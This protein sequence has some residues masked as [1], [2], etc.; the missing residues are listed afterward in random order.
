MANT[1]DFSTLI[2]SGNAS[3]AFLT[4]DFLTFNDSI[5]ASDLIIATSGANITIKL[6]TGFTLTLTSFTQKQVASTNFIFADGSKLIIG[7]GF[8]TASSDDLANTLVGTE[9]NDYLDGGLGIDTVSYAGANSAVTVDLSI[10]SA[11]DTIGA[12]TDKLLNIENI[13]GS[14]YSDTLAGDGNANS[15]DGGAGIDIMDGKNGSD[16]YFVTAGD[17]VTDTG[18]TGTDLVN[19]GVD[20]ALGAGIE[21]L[22]LTGTNAVNARGNGLNN[23]ITGNSAN[24]VLDGGAGDDSL[25]GS[26]GNDTYIV[27]SANDSIT[28]TS[29][30]TDQVISSAVSFDMSAKAV[31]VEILRLV[32]SATSG[33][34]NGLANTI[35]G[36]SGNNTLNGGAGI[37]TLTDLLGGNDTLIGGA[38][39]DTLKGGSGNDTLTGGVD[40]STGDGAADAM[41]GGTGNDTY[42]VTDTTDVV[43]EAANAGTDLVNTIVTFSLNDNASGNTSIGVENLTLTGTGNINGTGNSLANTITGNS[44]NNILI[45]GKGADSLVG[46]SGN[47]TLTGGGDALTSDGAADT[48][49]GGTG[50]DTYNVTD[51]TDVVNEVASAGTDL[52]NT[53]VTF[54][55]NDNASGNTSIGV[56]NLTLT[57]SAI[58]NGTGNSLANTITGNISNNTLFGLAGN[59]ILT[60]TLG[61]NDVLDGGTGADTMSGGLGNDT[62]IVD[63]ASD[64]V[65]EGSLLGTDLVKASV[66]YTLTDADIE[67]LTLTGSN[68]TTTSTDALNGTGNAAANTITGNNGDNTL[69]GGDNADNLQGGGGNDLLVGG[70]ADTGA[71]SGVTPDADSMAGG[72]GDDT[73]SVDFTNDVV[74]ELASQGTDLVKSRVTYTLL[75]VDVENLTLT[76]LTGVVTN[77]DAINGTGN[78]SANV[79]TGNA[80]NNILSGLGGVDTLTGGAGDDTLDGGSGADIMDGGAGNDTYIVDTTNTAAGN[81]DQINAETSGQGTDL[82][83]SSVT[84]TI[85]DVDVENLTLTGISA[86]N[87]TGNVSNN[88]LNGNGANNTLVGLDG[89]DTLD[90][91]A[92]ADTL[93]GGNGVDTYFVDDTGDTVDESTG[94]SGADHA[95]TT[96]ANANLDIVNASVTYTI[97]DALVENLT[98]TGTGVINGIGNSSANILIGNVSNNAL[99]AGAGND[100]IN[101]GIGKD[102]LTGGAGADM[103]TFTQSSDSSAANFDVITDFSLAGPD[104]IDLSAI[105]TGTLAFGGLKAGTPTTVSAAHTLDYYVS[106][107]NTFLIADTDGIASTIDFE[108]QLTGFTSTLTASSF[109][110]GHTITGTSS[111][112]TLK[113]GV[114][115]DTITGAGGADT[116]SGSLGNDKFV[117]ANKAATQGSSFAAGNTS[118]VNIDSITDF[119][120]N[121]SAV[122]DTIQLGIGSSAFG[123][124]TFT[125]STTASVNAVTVATA[126]TFTTLASA[127]QSASAGVASSNSTA[128]IYDVTVTA[129]T[130]AGHYAIINDATATITSSDTFISLTGITGALNSTDFLF[131]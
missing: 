19:A 2:A 120:G 123:T 44:G 31:T 88:I 124:M 6:S 3:Q 50:N 17:L 20:Y 129:G 18:T 47:D 27:D 115:N 9:F 36:N 60:D 105:D 64:S 87:G 23:T 90:G 86:I 116:M 80:G 122:G 58:I 39:V 97:T 130:L 42:N 66:T 51:T 103:F 38:G 94:T 63:N 126:G 10:T 1:Y 21:N 125:G 102:T 78:A 33:T 74:T 89:N 99:D 54:A 12:G 68:G 106:G 8:V 56:E 67:N 57:G 112:D 79:L 92:G 113:G 101:G 107:S 119:N 5:H 24:N 29:G 55:L 98:L 72:L 95:A 11:Q 7:D 71:I 117:I 46:G 128:Q 111:N 93:N 35:F 127:V 13:I 108:V 32:G 59:D 83:Q 96:V 41:T 25:N 118:A 84:Y 70:T 75:D 45:G 73:Y 82:V 77:T 16:T 52:V 104:V 69:I 65:S 15:L 81:G 85:F 110:L 62:Y 14:I 22:V 28:D 26:S 121:G 30:T 37:D 76:G 114:G 61:G 48:L 100:V 4:T 49:S 109:V 131:A 43:N 34:G 40:A 53:T 91:K